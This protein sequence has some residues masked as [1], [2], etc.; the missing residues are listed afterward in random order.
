[1]VTCYKIWAYGRV[2]GVGFRHACRQKALALALTGYARNLADGSVALLIQGSMQGTHCFIT[3]LQ[4]TGPRHASITDLI[5]EPGNQ[6]AALADF[7][8][9]YG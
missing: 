2:Q 1:M 7:S 3:W 5:T 9:G 4:T 8:I 6:P